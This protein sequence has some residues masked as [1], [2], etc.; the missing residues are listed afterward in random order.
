[1]GSMDAA[2]YHEIFP[3]SR[4]ELERLTDSG[5]DSAIIEGLLSAAFYDPEWRWV[6]NL[7]LR[8]LAD[9][10]SGIRSNAAMCLG[11][12]ARIHGQLDIEVVVPRLTELL[13]DTSIAPWAE[14]AL[15]DIK[16]FLKSQ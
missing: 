16:F 11:H 7:C 14:D 8:F 13:R 3:M 9:P 15:E 2:K 1:M 12:V 5:N 4:S 6:Q 10:D